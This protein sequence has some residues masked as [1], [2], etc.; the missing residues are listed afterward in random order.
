MPLVGSVRDA[1]DG[2]PLSGVEISRAELNRVRIAISA[3]DGNFSVN[4]PL[5]SALSFSA[6]GYQTRF[7]PLRGKDFDA[8]RP[9]DV[10]LKRG[11]PDDVR[12]PYEGVGMVLIDQ[13]P[14][15]WVREVFTGSPAELAGLRANDVLLLIDG[16]PAQAPAQ[17]NVI[18]LI[19][20]RAGTTVM[21]TVQRGNEQLQ[22]ALRR[23]LIRF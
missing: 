23:G 17:K 12:A 5:D 2:R 10:R 9:L 14:R 20:G 6:E 7:V 22:F 11:A 3:A 16:V 21:I 19:M 4:E 8:R 15:V 18:P 13:P 1:D